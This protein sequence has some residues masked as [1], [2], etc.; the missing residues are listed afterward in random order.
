MSHWRDAWLSSIFG[1]DVCRLDPPD[2]APEPSSR[3]FWYARVEAGDVERVRRLCRAGFYPVDTLVTL[4]ASAGEGATAAPI[5]I[6]PARPEHHAAVLRIAGCCF[7]QSRFHRDPAIPAALADTV[8]REWARSCLEGR[9]GDRVDVALEEGRP[10]GFLAL[11]SD[12]QAETIDLVGVDPE[13][14]GRGVG[15]AMVSTLLGRSRRHRV[16]VGT[17]L[18]NLTSLRFYQRL[19]FRIEGCRHVLHRHDA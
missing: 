11:M 4:E 17:Q 7:R 1:Y 18:A 3:A 8:K 12:A 15:T 6:E 5:R 10:V 9:R 14:Q 19:G 16:R 2:E 13:R